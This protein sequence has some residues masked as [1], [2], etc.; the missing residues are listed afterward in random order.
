MVTIKDVARTA[1]VSVATVS[2]VYN[3]FRGVREDTRE[4]VLSVGRR[5]GYSPHGAARSL[6]TNRTHTIGV[7]LPD[8][9]GEF[10]SELIRGI[11]EAVQ[12]T[13]FHVL[14]SSARRPADALEP[15]L[16]SMRGRVDGLILMVPELEAGT[17]R[18][19]LP[20]RFPLVLV[21][22]PL[23]DVPVPSIGVANAEGARAMVRHLAGLGHRR[24]AMI[25]GA[26][27]NFDATERLRG[28]RQAVAELGLVA[29]P[30]LEVPGDF[31]EAAGHA[32]TR[33]LLAYA[34][35][36]TAIFAANDGMAIG[37]LSALQDAGVQVP[38]EMAVA[39]FDD[40]PM[41]RYAHPP[42][43]S[44]HVDINDLGRRAT[45]RLL[46]ALDGRTDGTPARETL[47][48]TLV[49]RRSC[50]ARSGQE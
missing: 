19:T 27:H 22:S 49:L 17:A 35:R 18:R 31:S 24:I 1:G 50:G 26:E 45:A 23:S 14:L 43:S 32:A 20:D 4:R 7:L 47:A 39:G 15:V 8:L 6:V 9:Y 28:Y 44:V 48:T 38:E 3:G 41:A 30:A 5:L 16:R 29:D 12:G 25:C 2:R 46:D 21:N 34:Q 10:F 36:P 13:G 40:I 37:V 42:L 33:R 11:D